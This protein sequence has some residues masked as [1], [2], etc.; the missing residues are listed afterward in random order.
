MPPKKTTV[1]LG[2][3]EQSHSV[4]SVVQEQEEEEDHD[5]SDSSKC[6]EEDNDADTEQEAEASPNSDDKLQIVQTD[7]TLSATSAEA[8]N[9]GDTFPIFKKASGNENITGSQRDRIHSL[10]STRGHLRIS[11]LRILTACC[12]LYACYTFTSCPFAQPLPSLPNI[13]NQQTD[14]PLLLPPKQTH[15]L[16]HSILI[17]KNIA[18]G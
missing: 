17:C 11:S 15:S 12:Q 4:P 18:S 13:P 14:L 2:R 16:D 5:E 9:R 10:R 6:L 1:P 7:E 8:P 3:P